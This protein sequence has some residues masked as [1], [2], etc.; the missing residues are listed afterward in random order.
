MIT[1]SETFKTF[2]WISF[3]K[4]TDFDEHLDIDLPPPR[5]KYST[6][7]ESVHFAEGRDATLIVGYKL[8]IVRPHHFHYKWRLPHRSVLHLYT[9]ILFSSRYLFPAKS[10]CP[11]CKQAIQIFMKI[12]TAA[13]PNRKL[14]H[15]CV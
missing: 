8:N 1:R 13:P 9:V 11:A 12:R 5:G 7:A 3:K 2:V 14:R 15:I 4:S 10:I 6:L